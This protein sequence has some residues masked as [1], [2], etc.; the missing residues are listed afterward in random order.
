MSE[1]NPFPT[2]GYVD[3]EHFCDRID[4]LERLKEALNGG[5]HHTIVSLR[6]MGKTT[7]LDH[8][9]GKYS[10]SRG[11]VF[12]S[13]DVQGTQNFEEFNQVLATAISRTYLS[14]GGKI[15]SA[16]TNFLSR[17]RATLAVDPLSQ[18]PT[19]ELAIG[20]PSQSSK[21]L[22]DLMSELE[23]ASKRVVLAIDEVQQI[24][25]YPNTN[26]EALLRSVI[27]PLR[28]VSCIFAGSQ[29]D[30]MVAMFS[31]H[32]RPFYHSTQM[33]FLEPINRAVY[34]NFIRGRFAKTGRSITLPLAEMIYDSMRG[35]TFYVQLVCRRLWSSGQRKINTV[36][37][38]NDALVDTC[39][40]LEQEFYTYR[41]LLPSGQWDVL[42]AVAK[43]GSVASPSSKEFLTTHKL[44]LQ[45]STLKSIKALIEKELMYRGTDGVYFAYNPLFTWW[46]SNLT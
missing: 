20:T 7:L 10:K 21:T 46:A 19:V 26:S 45:G 15:T 41:N 5:S 42:M 40:E 29:K 31:D 32:R 12:L 22:S 43:Q 24:L 28:N 16:F 4:E 44:G 25:Q 17:F 1:V 8:F 2:S 27:Q 37:Q 3:Q 13:I 6:R 38:V 14:S 18:L 34:A 23:S 39:K 33:M 11:V 9:I 35:H 30:L 36:E